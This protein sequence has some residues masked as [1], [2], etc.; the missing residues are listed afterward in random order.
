MKYP[1]LLIIIVLF[2]TSSCKKE[3]NFENKIL[4]KWN[5]ESIKKLEPLLRYSDIS[6]DLEYKTIVF[7]DN[8]T[9][10]LFLNNSVQPV[11]GSW[12]MSYNTDYIYNGDEDGMGTVVYKI[13]VVISWISPLQYLGN[14]LIS[15][16][17][18]HKMSFYFVDGSKQIIFKCNK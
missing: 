8:H 4:G 14:I 12:E 3:N 7:N 10:Q 5:I 6:D 2:F 13:K 11:E 15:T 9:V 16:L 17:T 18:K 1:I